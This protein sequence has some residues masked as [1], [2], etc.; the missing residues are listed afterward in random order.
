MDL[1]LRRV[2]FVTRDG[3]VGRGQVFLLYLLRWLRLQTDVD[4]EVLSWHDGPLLDQ[5]G[6]LAPVQVLAE[7]D[8][9]RPARVAEV[10][11]LQ[12]V[13]SALKSARL[14]WWVLQRRRTDLLYLNGLEAARLLAFAVGP[15]PHAVVHVHDVAELDGD[16][17]SAAD[18][19]VIA[20]R[21]A[22]FVAASDEIVD[23]LS[24]ELGVPRDRIVRHDYVIAAGGESPLVSL[25][26]PTRAE[27]GVDDD[28][29]VVGAFGPP[30]WWAE[31]EQFVLFAWALRRRL[32]TRPIRFLWVAEDDDERAL[33]PLRHDLRNAGLDDVT[34]VVHGDRPFDYLQ[35]MDVLVCSTRR[36][37]AE[38]LVFEAVGLGTAV[39]RTDNI[40]RDSPAGRVA[41]AVPYLD[42]D[43]LVETVAGLATDEAR[44]KRLVEQGC[45]AAR[46][47]HDVSVGARRLLAEVRRR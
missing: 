37:P 29:F 8:A 4:A 46:G 39:V 35:A 15:V 41:P 10:L 19:A 34:L 21:A 18:R 43:A 1:G 2:V 13:T 6:E 26:P 23:A 40:L 47:H 24:S 16:R 3:T 32:P 42:V 38:L 28:A 5:Y 12:R 31:P 17:L 11:G 20:A 27:L 25:R 30:D 45:E 36:E 22:V 44:R 9:W 7:L 33:W 14:R